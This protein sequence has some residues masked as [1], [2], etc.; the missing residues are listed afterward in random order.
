MLLA[1]D[2]ALAIEKE[3]I[4]DIVAECNLDSFHVSPL[5]IS[6]PDPYD[7]RLQHMLGEL[8][9]DV[10]RKIPME[11]LS[12]ISRTFRDAIRPLSRQDALSKQVIDEVKK[13]LSIGEWYILKEIFLFLIQY[14]MSINVFVKST[15]IIDS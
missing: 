3:P 4:M 1:E 12:P 10:G 7:P 14:Y 6:L 13:M 11:N 15:S 9:V 5:T 2:I 8:N